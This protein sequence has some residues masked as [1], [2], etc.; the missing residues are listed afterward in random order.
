MLHGIYALNLYNLKN[1]P[2]L[3]D[4]TSNGVAPKHPQTMA[5]LTYNFVND[6]QLDGLVG[7]IT[8]L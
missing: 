2:E 6:C 4:F 3:Y 8:F 7:N 5:M 1:K